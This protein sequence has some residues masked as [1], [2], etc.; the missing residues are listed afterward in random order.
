MD[1]NDHP[2]R[3]YP[4]PMDGPSHDGPVHGALDPAAEEVGAHE[5]D[6]VDEFNLAVR[7]VMGRDLDT[8]AGELLDAAGREVARKEMDD[9]IAALLREIPGNRQR[10]FV[11]AKHGPDGQRISIQ[12]EEVVAFGGPDDGAGDSA[13]SQLFVDL[14]DGKEQCVYG[15]VVDGEGDSF[16]YGPYDAGQA[17][18]HLLAMGPMLHALEAE[19]GQPGDRPGTVLTW[20]RTLCS[21]AVSLSKDNYGAQGGALGWDVAKQVR[22]LLDGSVFNI[23]SI[24]TRPVG[25]TEFNNG[26]RVFLN[27]NIGEASQVAADKMGH[28]GR[29]AV[30]ITTAGADGVHKGANFG[31]RRNADGSETVW[32]DD[33]YGAAARRRKEYEAD[34]DEP[35]AL[36]AMAMRKFT[37]VLNA[38]LASGRKQ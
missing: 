3:G 37:A 24:I 2:D 5:P 4:F 1:M 22:L 33:N 21:T 30:D 29:Q 14:N 6:G 28:V 25:H 12:C 23:Q 7:A 18:R 19:Y 9:A 11:M 34:S 10:R 32:A 15:A 16:A 26:S 20:F 38:A 13:H 17:D 36:D 8:G 35:L 27:W 31:Y